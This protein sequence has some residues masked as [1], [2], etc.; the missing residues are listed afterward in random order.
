MT[1]PRAQLLDEVAEQAARDEKLRA[2]LEDLQQVT[3]PGYTLV[4]GQLLY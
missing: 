2:I 4:Q 1:V 3:T